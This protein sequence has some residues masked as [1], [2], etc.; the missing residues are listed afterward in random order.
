VQLR[1]ALGALH[2]V[3]AKVLGIVLTMLPNKGTD[4][5]A[6]GR[7]GYASSYGAPT[8]DADERHPQPQHA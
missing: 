5:Y 6:F 3:D 8:G 1:A 7:Y 2:Q 4:A